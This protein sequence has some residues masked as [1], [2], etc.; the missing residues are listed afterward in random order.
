MELMQIGHKHPKKA[1]SRAENGPLGSPRT[2]GTVGEFD[3]VVEDAQAT[4]RGHGE[5][6]AGTQ[7]LTPYE[8]PSPRARGAGLEDR[9]TDHTRERGPAFQRAPGLPRVRV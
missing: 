8:G 6:T 1:R 5:Q 2:R 9:R 4:P 7:P 3:E